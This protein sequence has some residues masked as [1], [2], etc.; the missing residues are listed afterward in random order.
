MNQQQPSVSII[1]PAYRSEATIEAS[2]ASMACQD[3]PSAEVVVVESSPGGVVEE[4]V[5]SRFPAIKYVASPD[6]LLPHAARN[7]GAQNC[8]ADLLVFT[9]PD[10][11]APPNWL[12]KMVRAHEQYG[13]VIVGSLE[14]ATARWLDRGIHLGK[15]DMFLPGGQP[16]ASGYCATGNMLCSRADFEKVGGFDG[17]EMLGDLLISWKF[18]ER[19]I[20]ITFVPAASV[21]HH[22]TQGF[23]IH[24]RGTVSAWE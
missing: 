2:L 7:L 18:S 17:D 24:L 23:A 1:I 16:R 20:P 4:L 15:F 22:H 8:Q 5:R 3:Y 12:A 14:N 13:G 6:R 11:Y 19:K 9:D 10:I 21:R